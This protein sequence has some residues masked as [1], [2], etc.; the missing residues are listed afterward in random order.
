MLK[1]EINDKVHVKRQRDPFKYIQEW[2]KTTSNKYNGSYIPIVTK[3][4]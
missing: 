3:E 1:R 4:S 2:S